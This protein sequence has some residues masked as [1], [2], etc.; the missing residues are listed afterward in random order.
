MRE[1]KYDSFYHDR[2]SNNLPVDVLRGVYV[3]D[4]ELVGY[5]NHMFCP[6]CR[7]AELHYVGEGYRNGFLRANPSSKHS[8]SCPYAYEVA[9]SRI[10]AEYVKRISCSDRL[11]RTLNAALNKTRDMIDCTS[12]GLSDVRFELAQKVEKNTHVETKKYYGM[13]F[14]SLEANF[15]ESDFGH[16]YLFYGKTMFDIYVGDSYKFFNFF[17]KINDRNKIVTFSNQDVISHKNVF[18]DKDKIYRVAMWGKLVKY[19]TH[20]KERYRIV[21]VFDKGANRLPDSNFIKIEELKG[22]CSI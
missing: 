12:F 11:E 8:E 14:K 3:A 10:V 1:A 20:S 16:P 13:P 15:D 5:R 2:T 7:K 21:S 22:D 6:D 9:S 17:L 18:I 19:A 4:R